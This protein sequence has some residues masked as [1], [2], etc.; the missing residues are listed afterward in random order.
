[1][2][3]M[4]YSADAARSAS[5]VMPAAALVAEAATAF[6][7]PVLPVI[8][9]SASLAR[10]GDVLAPVTAIAARPIVPSVFMVIAAAT[11]T[12]AKRDAGCGNFTYALPVRPG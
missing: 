2:R 5:V 10:Y 8:A 4:R 1:M 7:S 3:C 6:A 11:P 9:R 12:S